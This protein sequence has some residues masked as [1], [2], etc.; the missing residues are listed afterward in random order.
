ML[1]AAAEDKVAVSVANFAAVETP[2][3]LQDTEG[4]A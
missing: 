3:S 4:L 2:L 1:A